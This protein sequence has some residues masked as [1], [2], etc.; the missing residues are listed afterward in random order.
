MKLKE[1]E[2]LNATF[3]EWLGQGTSLMAIDTANND[4]IVAV[5]A[6][7]IERRSDVSVTPDKECKTGSPIFDLL[8]FAYQR[9]N[10]WA[11]YSVDQLM[12]FKYICVHRG[13][14]GL[15]ISQH[16]NS[17]T[18]DL[19]RKE[20]IPLAYVIATSG[21]SQAVLKRMQ[22]TVVDEM[23]YEDY[24]VDGKVVFKPENPIHSGFATMIKWV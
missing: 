2:E 13:Y 12:H 9:H 16:I 11:K 14:R 21:Y 10:P 24:K 23:K 5:R 19:M 8:N 17:L 4:M 6:H 1:S 22:F 18:F 15:N 20:R 7:Q 3:R